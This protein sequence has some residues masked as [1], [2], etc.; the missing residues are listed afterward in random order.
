MTNRVVGG[1][2]ELGE[3]NLPPLNLNND[4]VI[5]N[6]KFTY[7]NGNYIVGAMAVLDGNYDWQG[8]LSQYEESACGGWYK[9]TNGQLVAD[10]VRKTQIMNA[11]EE[12]KKQAEKEAQK[13][14]A[15]VTYT[16]MMTDTMIED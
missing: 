3:S 13:I 2:R 11:R 9:L 10:N 14:P 5:N 7:D 16:A 4:L 8:Q 6:Y 12:A 15:Q 1:Y